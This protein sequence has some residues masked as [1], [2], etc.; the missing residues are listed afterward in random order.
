MKSLLILLFITSNGMADV[1]YRIVYENSSGGVTIICPAEN[2][3]LSQGQHIAGYVPQ[4]VRRRVIP[5]NLIP[6]DRSRRDT[7]RY[8]ASRNDGI[9]IP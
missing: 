4:G 1:D 6:T 2:S 7:W 8:S 3:G 9:E 5:T